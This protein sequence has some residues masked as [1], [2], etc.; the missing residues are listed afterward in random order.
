MAI[1]NMHFHEV[2]LHGHPATK[3]RDT[4]L[5]KLK[6]L[7]TYAKNIGADYAVFENLF[8]VKNRT[9]TASSSANRKITRFA[10][11]QLLVHGII[12][13][14]K[15]GLTPVLVDPRGTTTSEEHE[16]VMK[17]RGLDKHTASAYLIALRGLGK[18]I[19]NNIKPYEARTP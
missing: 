1:K 13:A 16:R 5:K 19:S 10:K 18:L 17:T 9:K 4:R 15:L 2:S 8:V 11:R 14:L 7:P 3:A 6:K 12:M